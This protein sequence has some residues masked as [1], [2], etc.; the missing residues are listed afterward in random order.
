MKNKFIKFI[1]MN[2]NSILRLAWKIFSIL[3]AIFGYFPNIMD[4]NFWKIM[5]GELGI[6]FLSLAISTLLI[7]NF[8]SN[9]I[10]NKSGLKLI[11]EYGDLL[12]IA[13]SDSERKNS[14]RIVVIPV[15]T[16]FDTIIDDNLSGITKPLVSLNTLHGRWIKKI[17]ATLHICE[18]DRRIVGYLK[19]ATFNLI[20]REQ[21]VRGNLKDYERGTIAVFDYGQTEFFLLALSRFDENNNAQCT[22]DEFILSMRKLI[23]FIDK[24]SQ[25]LPV[26]MPLMGTNLSRA[27]MTHK[28]SLQAM[29]ALIKL[30]AD[31]LKSEINIVIYDGDRDKV[32]IYDV[33]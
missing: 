24:N 33:S 27:N 14:K 28:E 12:K 31:K 16:A 26:Y 8:R 7:Y 19:D 1:N 30:Y 6:Y 20:N 5:L 32:T 11:V 13:F 17:S 21:K 25:G 2:S 23:D 29:V 3:L 9:K 18:I 22:K 10:I 15:N 4:T